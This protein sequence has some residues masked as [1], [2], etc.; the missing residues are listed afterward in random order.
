M[1]FP[2]DVERR[3]FEYAKKESGAPAA[4]FVYHSEEVP[5]QMIKSKMECIGAHSYHWGSYGMER[6]YIFG[7]LLALLFD[8]AKA[9]HIDVVEAVKDYLEYLETDV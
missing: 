4:F 6:K 8:E 5:C 1:I 2:V 3:I 7:M 9:N